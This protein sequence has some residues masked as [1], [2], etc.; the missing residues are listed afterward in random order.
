[1]QSFCR[2]HCKTS[3]RK[4]LPNAVQKSSQMLYGIRKP[5]Y[6]VISHVTLQAC[7]LWYTAICSSIVNTLFRIM[8]CSLYILYK[9]EMILQTKVSLPCRESTAENFIALGTNVVCSQIFGLVCRWVWMLIL[10]SCMF[11]WLLQCGYLGYKGVH[12][13]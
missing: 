7:T 11:L 1:M 10:K 13:I 4:A 2:N 8:P 3:S 12:L 9:G 5:C 6:D